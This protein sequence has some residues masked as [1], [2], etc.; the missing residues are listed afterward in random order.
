[1]LTKIFKQMRMVVYFFALFHSARSF[2][3]WN[4][5]KL[6]WLVIEFKF[7]N[8]KEPEKVWKIN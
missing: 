5:T 7:S 3:K 8:V 6:N 4:V 2:M 1:M